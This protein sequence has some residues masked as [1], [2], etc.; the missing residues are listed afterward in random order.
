[1]AP[2]LQRRAWAAVVQFMGKL[3]VIGGRNN[4]LFHD[5]VEYYASDTDKWTMLAPLNRKRSGACAVVSN[6][7]IYVIGG[8]NDNEQLTTIE[9]F[10]SF[11]N[12][13]FEVIFSKNYS[14][15]IDLST[16]CVLIWFLSSSDYHIAGCAIIVWIHGG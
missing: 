3:Y 11:N 14:K 6:G 4:S 12:K 10:D 2:M 9:M 1:M 15:S 8:H 7:I 13:W 5:S 16:N